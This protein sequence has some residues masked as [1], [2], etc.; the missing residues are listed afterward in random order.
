MSYS[1]GEI[2]RNRD[3]GWGQRKKHK[4][5]KR[6]GGRGEGEREGGRERGNKTDQR[7][8]ADQGQSSDK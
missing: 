3:V 4:T 7:L 1:R 2:D 5:G 8:G 6:E